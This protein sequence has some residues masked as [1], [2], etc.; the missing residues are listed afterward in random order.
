MTV[1][2]L[3]Y[4]RVAAAEPF[5]RQLELVVQRHAVVSAGRVLDALEGGR[6]LPA[7]AVLLL[8]HDEPSFD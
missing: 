2:V 8:V 5:E 4:G 1:H 6:P 7:R 3:A